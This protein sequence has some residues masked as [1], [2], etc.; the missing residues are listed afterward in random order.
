MQK[1]M[2]YSPPDYVIK[3]FGGVRKT[4]RH[5]GRSATAV[6]IWRKKGWIPSSAQRMIY[7]IA[8]RD[9]LDIT[10]DDLMNGRMVY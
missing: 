6:S 9:G 1:K 10:P 5:V 4:S 8:Q 7:N 3:V 2:K